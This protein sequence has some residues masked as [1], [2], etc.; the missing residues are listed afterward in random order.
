[1]NKIETLIEKFCNSRGLSLKII[2]GLE[3]EDLAI[4]SM[5]DVSPGKW[6]LAHTTWFFDVFLLKDFEDEYTFFNEKY[7]ELFN[8]YYKSQG[9]NWSRCK[10][11]LLSRPTLNEI[12]LY[13]KDID[14]RVINLLSKKANE[15]QIL[16]EIG[17]NHE[18]QHQELMLMDLKHVLGINP[19]YP[20]WHARDFPQSSMIEE[21]F[22]YITG[23]VK[24]IGQDFG[25][26]FIF[27]NESPR[28]KEYVQDY[29]LSNKLVTNGEYLEFITSDDYRN[30]EYWLSD[31]WDLAIAKPLYWIEDEKNPGCYLES[32]P[33]G[34]NEIDLNA[35]VCHISYF[36]ASAYAAWRGC[37]LPSEKEWE[38]AAQTLE[39][40]GQF[41]NQF[42]L[43]P[44]VGHLNGNFYDMFGVLWQWTSSHYETYPGYKKPH[45]ALGEY[46]AKF[47]NAQRVLKGGSF[48]TLK[49]HFRISYRNFFQAN[50]QWPF[51]GIRLA[52]DQNEL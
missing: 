25:D 31:G 35:P 4:Q 41:F 15:V 27:D 49:E 43:A 10:R 32:S 2:E 1:M 29:F 23:G 33:Y 12:L 44:K 24:E 19:I 39:V 8:S 5:E 47:T 21:N 38:V 11:G 16:I 28:H 17:I 18:Q 37:R 9:K 30:P 26:Q 13:R 7:H 48:A 36:E 40:N 46:N 6:H 34:L 22:I 52:K 20:K 42:D 3:T 45:G 50:K 51:T 14:E